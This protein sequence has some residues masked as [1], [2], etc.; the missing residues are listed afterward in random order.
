MQN[1]KAEDTHT[2]T[3]KTL[4]DPAIIS[5]PNG[6]LDDLVR[7]C[8]P[9]VGIESCIMIVDPKFGLAEFECTPVTYH[10][11]LVQIHRGKIFP[12]FLGP[13]LERTSHHSYILLL[14]WYLCKKNFNVF[15]PLEQ[16]ERRL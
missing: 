4:P 7:F 6:Q 9:S 10:Q 8:A 15:E 16:M 12:V 1:E 13:A 5:A 2:H 11:L 3:I 14:P